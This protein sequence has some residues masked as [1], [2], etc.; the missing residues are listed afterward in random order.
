MKSLLTFAF[1]SLG[2]ALARPALA[3][4]AAAP[5]AGEDWQWEATLYMLGAAM[6]GTTGVNSLTADVDVGF[7]EILENLEFG[8]MGR[9]HAARGPWGIGLDVIYMGLGASS[10]RPPADVDL[11]QTAIELSAD[12]T[13]NP[14]FASVVGVRYIDLSV[15]IRF[16]GPL[17][18]QRSPSIDWWDPFVGANIRAPLGEKWSFRGRTDIGGFGVGSDLA[19]QVEAMFDWRLSER[20]SFQVGYRWIDMD[21]EDD[22]SGFVYDMV[23]QGPQAAA[24]FRF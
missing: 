23:I 21:Y 2:T 24:M 4:N 14:Y 7:D 18:L 3:E 13:Y 8:A 6:D 10:D 19:W 17:G 1:L 9:L 12:F 16:Q 11:D 22:D 15:D 5:A 20:T